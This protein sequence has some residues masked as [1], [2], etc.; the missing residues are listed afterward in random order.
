MQI[1]PNPRNFKIGLDLVT[2][3]GTPVEF[4]LGFEHFDFLVFDIDHFAQVTNKRWWSNS[5]NLVDRSLASA[6]RKFFL[7][8]EGLQEREL[9]FNKLEKIV[10]ADMLTDLGAAV[11]MNLF[12]FNKTLFHPP[13]NFLLLGNL[14]LSAGNSAHLRL[15]QIS[16]AATS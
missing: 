15:R 6:T 2:H 9:V 10:L 12:A 1:L 3:T 13:L 4:E 5:Y 11:A 7:F 16:S 14:P 8:I